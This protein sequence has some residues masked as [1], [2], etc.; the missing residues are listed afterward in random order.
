MSCE[1]KER[2]PLASSTFLYQCLCKSE[3]M[4]Y[5][6]QQLKISNI[7]QWTMALKK[8]EGYS[9]CRL[10]IQSSPSEREWSKISFYRQEIDYWVF[11]STCVW[12]HMSVRQK[13]SQFSIQGGFFPFDSDCQTVSPLFHTDPITMT[14]FSYFETRFIFPVGIS[15]CPVLSSILLQLFPLRNY[16]YIRDQQDYPLSHETDYNSQRL[17]VI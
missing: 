3:H 12:L 11:C 7:H 6:W 17:S 14:K 4:A 10:C 13:I 1:M 15:S 2:P 5:L 8:M 9:A 16:L